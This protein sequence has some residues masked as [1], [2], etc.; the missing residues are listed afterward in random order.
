MKT[1]LLLVPIL[2]LFA[3]NGN[4]NSEKIK[5][6]ENELSFKNEQLENINK[7]LKEIEDNSEP[8]LYSKLLGSWISYEDEDVNRPVLWTL[9]EDG[10]AYLTKDGNAQ[11]KAKWSFNYQNFSLDIEDP[12]DSRKK[13]SVKFKSISDNEFIIIGRGEEL[14]FKKLEL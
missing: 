10:Y 12:K 1:L 7:E 6:L 9:K 11:Q 14:K 5:A 3:C 2:L 13:E 8:A 4:N